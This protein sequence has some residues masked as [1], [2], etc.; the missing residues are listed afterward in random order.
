MKLEPAR[1]GDVAFP[2]LEDFRRRAR[3]REAM[4]ALA[5]CSAFAAG[6]AL[7][8]LLAATVG[9]IVEAGS[10]WLLGFLRDM[11]LSLPDALAAVL[12]ILVSA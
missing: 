9:W 3:R 12:P 6:I 11:G 5:M 4:A 7:V 1:Q 8:A 10:G 2:N